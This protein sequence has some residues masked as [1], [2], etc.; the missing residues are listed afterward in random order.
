MQQKSFSNH[1]ILLKMHPGNMD[2]TTAIKYP[3]ISGSQLFFS[4]VFYKNMGEAV[5][6]WSNVVG[7]PFLLKV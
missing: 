6:L 2:E 4:S 7:S 1:L 5:Q 3:K